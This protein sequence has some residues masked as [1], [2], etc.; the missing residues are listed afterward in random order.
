MTEKRQS[1]LGSSSESEAKG[2]PEEGFRTRSLW[3]GKIV[4][5]ISKS[6][7]KCER[8]KVVSLNGSDKKCTCNE[9]INSKHNLKSNTDK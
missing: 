1:Y 4:K 7:S 8:V 6:G 9:K 5:K 2:T 3:G